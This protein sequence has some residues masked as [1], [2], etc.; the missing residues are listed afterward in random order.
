MQLCIAIKF[1]VWG[2]RLRIQL[3]RHRAPIG[4][5]S[6]GNPIAQTTEGWVALGRL[7]FPG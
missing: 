4:I 6:D 2:W 3:S 5:H 1:R 7:T